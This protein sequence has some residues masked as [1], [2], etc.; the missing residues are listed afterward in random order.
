M[1][2]GAHE[3]IPLYSVEAEMSTL[4]AMLLSERAAEEIVTILNDEDFY[5]P[6]HGLIFNAMKQ[7][8]HNHKP[9]DTVTLENELK[10]RGYL[11]DAGGPNYLL[12]LANITPSASN[13]NYYAQ[14]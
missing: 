11:A 12:E 14:I 4:G 9:I 10:A 1:A 7:L 5:R 2:V 3:L 6:A 13:S 8:I